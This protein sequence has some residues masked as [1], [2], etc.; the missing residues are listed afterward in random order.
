MGI[1]CYAFDQHWILFNPCNVY[2]DCPRG[3]PR[4]GQNVQ[5]VTFGYL[6]S[7]WVSCAA[8]NVVSHSAAN[9]LFHMDSPMVPLPED[10]RAIS[11]SADFRRQLVTFALLLMSSN[12]CFKWLCNSSRRCLINV[13]LSDI[14]ADLLRMH[15]EKNSLGTL[16]TEAFGL[17]S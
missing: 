1:C 13:L 3:V 9:V 16:H 17:A 6:I 14:C 11:H 8:R 15:P 4:G 2:R 7:W 5:K 10:S 12:F